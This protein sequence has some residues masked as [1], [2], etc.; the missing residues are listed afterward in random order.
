[1]AGPALVIGGVGK[2]KG[3]SM[4][5]GSPEEEASESTEEESKEGDPEDMHLDDAFDAMQSG[6]KQAFREA[7]KKCLLA[8]DSGGYTGPGVEGEG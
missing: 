3:G 6:D 7:M 1:M 8:S 2:P 5:E 4:D